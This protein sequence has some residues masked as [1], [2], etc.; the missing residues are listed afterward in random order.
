MQPRAHR[1]P[2]P[3]LLDAPALPRRAQTK[4]EPKMTARDYGE[5]AWIH[6]CVSPR[7]TMFLLLMLFLFL[8]FLLLFFL[9]CVARF[10]TSE[11]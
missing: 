1:T 6:P 4:G 10:L 3:R 11:T 5:L 7:Q 2:R 9:L 8:L